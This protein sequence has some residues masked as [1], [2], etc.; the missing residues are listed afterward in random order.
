MVGGKQAHAPCEVLTLQQTL[1]L[2]QLNFIEI[3]RLP[4]SRREFGHTQL[5]GILPDLKQ[6]CLSGKVPIF[7][8]MPEMRKQ[9]N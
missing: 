5:L 3:V 2:C 8:C 6:W 1:F 7:T 4:Q 9:V